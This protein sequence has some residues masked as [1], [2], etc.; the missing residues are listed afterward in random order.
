MSLLALIDADTPV[1]SAAISADDMEEWVAFSRLNTTIDNII[2]AS[3]CTEYKLYVSG[4]GNFR[5]EISES[6]KAQ[7]PP[8]PKHREA[9]RKWL[10]ENRGAI[11]CNGYE[12]DDA[13][14]C[15]QKTDGSTIICGID[16]DLLQIPGL[17]YT[18]P[19][20]RGGKVVKEGK[21]YDISY[22][23]GMRRFFTQV[24]TGDTS[25]NIK[26]I[27]KIGPKKAEFILSNCISEEDYYNVCK[28]AYIAVEREEDFY[29]NLDL[30]WIW[31]SYGITYNIRREL[32]E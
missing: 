24:L 26:G 7:R 16:K 4:K 18:W 22:E 8:S 28:E 3:G 9:C 19:I 1:I 5:K 15:E 23:E 31:R 20:T 10:I 32:N 13:V 21:F 25:D 6:Y 14:G 27:H 30:L 29:T 17:H 12:A 11:E 2:E